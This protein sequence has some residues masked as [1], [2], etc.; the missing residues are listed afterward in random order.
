MPDGRR[1]A[2][3]ATCNT[4]PAIVELL[5]GLAANLQAGM[6]RFLVCAEF[7]GQYTCPLAIAC[8]SRGCAL[9]LE[10]PTQ[11]KL[12]SGMRRG[13]NDS[14]RRSDDSRICNQ[15]FGQGEAS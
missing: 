5:R 4:Q 12:S 1:L 14:R 15:I 10:N 13:R 8:K 6:G 9:W 11:I 7:T 3:S 2:E